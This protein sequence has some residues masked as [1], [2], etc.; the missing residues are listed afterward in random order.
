MTSF[1]STCRLF[2]FSEEGNGGNE[3]GGN[4]GNEEG[5]KVRYEYE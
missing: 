5:R 3:E 2:V 1:L 4:G